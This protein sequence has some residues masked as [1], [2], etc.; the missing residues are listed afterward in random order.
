MRKKNAENHSPTYTALIVAMFT[1]TCTYKFILNLS[2]AKSSGLLILVLLVRG[3]TL[4]L[5]LAGPYVNTIALVAMTRIGSLDIE[6]FPS[7]PLTALQSR[8]RHSHVYADICKT[9][10]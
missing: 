6:L 10:Q 5:S 1:S 8:L 7:L 4:M 2:K 3:A 9:A